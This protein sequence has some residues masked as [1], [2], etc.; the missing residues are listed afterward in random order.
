MNDGRKGSSRSDAPPQDLRRERDELLQSFSRGTRATEE[1]IQEHE[2]LQVRLAELETEN[3]KLRATV[4]ADHA[5]RELLEKIEK[6]ESE[7][8]ELLSR[9]RR[10]EA[11]SSE[12]SSRVHEVEAEFANLA[13][14]YVASNQLHSSL[15]PRAVTRRIKEVLAQFVGAERYCVYLAS[16]D[17]TEL[18]PIA[19]EGVPGA[20]LTPLRVDGSAAQEVFRTGASVVEEEQDPSRGTSLR[21]AALIPLS[22]DDRVVGVIAIHSTLAQ[23]RSFDTVDFQLF[24][25]L[26]QHAAAALVSAS[27]FVQAGR[28][29]PGLEAF[30]D[31]SV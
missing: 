9:T 12:V 22:V 15:S 30:L 2:R 18:V 5:M 3:A 14:L 6:L 27:L 29:L 17:G 13:N 10:A 25:L 31:L 11:N 24:K 16:T 7:K 23:K 28:R 8:E 1:F 21:P 19:S 26:G 4:Q 20:E